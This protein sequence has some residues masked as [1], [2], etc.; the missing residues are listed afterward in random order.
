[1]LI[2]ERETTEIISVKSYM[3]TLM[4]GTLPII[5]S[6]LLWKWSRDKNVRQSKRNLCIAYLTIKYTLILPITACVG[7]ICYIFGNTGI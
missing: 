3:G 4:L 5:G 2:G 7:I 6:I 1:M